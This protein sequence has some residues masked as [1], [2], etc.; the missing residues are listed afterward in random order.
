MNQKLKQRLKEDGIF[1]AVFLTFC[2]IPSL[3]GIWG[4]KFINFLITLF[5]GG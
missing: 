1:F 4:R 2:L 3:V 5:K